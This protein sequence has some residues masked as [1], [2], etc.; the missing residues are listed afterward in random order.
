MCDVCE[1]YGRDHNFRTNNAPLCVERFYKVFEN[2]KVATV[3]MCKLCSI[4]FFRV[5]EWRFLKSH[6][7]FARTLALQKPQ[8]S[9]EYDFNL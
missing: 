3:K 4:E 5:G 2:N 6:L 8:E 1:T 9:D 7:D